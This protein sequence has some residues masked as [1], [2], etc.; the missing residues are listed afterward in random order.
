MAFPFRRTRRVPRANAGQRD[1]PRIGLPRAL[2]AYRY[3]PLWHRFLTELGCTVVASPATNKDILAAGIRVTVDDVCIPLKAYVGHLLYLK[4]QGVDGI[5]VP[6]VFAIENSPKRRFTCPKFMGLPD[7]ARAVLDGSPRLLDA[8]L[9]VRERPVADTFVEIGRMLERSKKASLAAYGAAA[10]AQARF[11]AGR[12]GGCDF[13]RAVAAALGGNPGP[14]GRRT[15]T[16]PP[17]T[18]DGE[19]AGVAPATGPEAGSLAEA[20]TLVIATVGHPYLLSDRFLSFSLYERLERLGV[21]VVDAVSVQRDALE[22]EAA[23]YA[24][25]SWSYEREILGAVSHFMTRADV[26]GI[27]FLTSFACGTF[28]VVSEIV[29]REV[30]RRASKPVLYLI[31]DEMTGEAGIQ[32]RLESFCDMLVDRELRTR[33]CRMAGG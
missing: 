25:I 31:V 16:S 28:P 26:D 32:T 4:E 17:G 12:A 30:R 27:V 21:R 33:G 29:E 3:F 11:D 9:N 18:E 19:G 2:L 1:G 10:E 13:S 24:E 6:R 7:L 15:E 20:T 22:R 14:A 8:D 5:M 23:K